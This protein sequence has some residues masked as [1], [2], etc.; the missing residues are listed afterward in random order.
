VRAAHIKHLPQGFGRALSHFRSKQLSIETL[1][2]SSGLRVDEIIRMERGEREPSLSEFLRLALALN[3]APGRLFNRAVAEWPDDPDS[4]PPFYRS[5]AHC[6]RLFRLAWITGRRVI[7]ESRKAFETIDEAARASV[8][9]NAIRERQRLPPL[10]GV[11]VYIRTGNIWT[12][13]DF[14]SDGER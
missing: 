6:P 13:K 3:V 4:G 7:H 2:R 1:A 11:G 8:G 5:S 12:V 14:T 10:I 9:L